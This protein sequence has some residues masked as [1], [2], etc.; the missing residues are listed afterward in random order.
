MI[1]IL[2][3]EDEQSDKLKVSLMGHA[4]FAQKGNDVICAGVSVLVQSI[5]N[6]LTEVLHYKIPYRIADGYFYFEVPYRYLIE[7][8]R[9]KALMDTL[10]I[11]LKDLENTNKK[12]IK[13]ITEEVR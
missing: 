7:D 3:L 2:F 11:N 9:V 10:L 12:H 4:N 8:S 1:K 13:L 6:G 5:F